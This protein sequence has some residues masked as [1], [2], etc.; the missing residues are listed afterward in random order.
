MEQTN[1]I[2]MNPPAANT[3]S[4]DSGRAEV[5]VPERIQKTNPISRRPIEHIQLGENQPSKAKIHA[6]KASQRSYQQAIDRLKRADRD[7][8]E[9]AAFIAASL[10]TVT[11][12]QA[13]IS[14][15]KDKL[16]LSQDVLQLAFHGYIVAF[17][18]ILLLGAVRGRSAIRRRAQAEMDIDQSKK[19]IFEYCPMDQWPKLEE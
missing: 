18:L 2:K 13:V 8:G 16:E 14:V 19:G 15:A 4:I 9:T 3:R 5:W 6:C 1:K 17:I 10:T 7:L 11:A 12:V